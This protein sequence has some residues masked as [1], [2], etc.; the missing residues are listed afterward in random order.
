M[1]KVLA[2]AALVAGFTLWAG[3]GSPDEKANKLFVEACGLVESAKQV[4][5]TSYSGAFEAYKEA[6][7]KI[8]RIISK[9]PSSRL[10]VDLTQGRAMVGPYTL[11]EFKQTTVPIARILAEAEKSL[12][13]CALFPGRMLGH[14]NP[15]RAL[16]MH[17]E[18]ARA[19]ARAGR[20]DKVDAVL[21][22]LLKAM[23]LSEDADDNEDLLEQIASIYKDTGLLE[24]A[25]QVA[26]RISD[27]SDRGRMLAGI[28]KAC[29]DTLQVG[30]MTDIA[31]TIDY[32]FSR[33]EAVIDIAP[34]LLE[35]GRAPR[36]W[37]MLED[38]VMLTRRVGTE[39]G[40][41]TLLARIAR[42]FAGVGETDRA[43]EILAE[44]ERYTQ[45]VSDRSSKSWAI[46]NIALAYMDMDDMT[47]AL[48]WV[49]RISET[50]YRAGALADAVR[51]YA[52]AGDYD[53]VEALIEESRTL[54]HECRRVPAA[55]VEAYVLAGH[56][57][58]AVA[59]AGGIEDHWVQPLLVERAAVACARAGDFDKAL[60]ITALASFE[61]TGS[62]A[63]LAL[64][65]EYATAG[66][67][68][69]A[70][71]LAGEIKSG[72]DLVQLTVKIASSC[73]D[74][75][76]RDKAVELLDGVPVEN[77]QSL[78]LQGYDSIVLLTS[79]AIEYARA[80][81]LE[82]ALEAGNLVPEPYDKLRSMTYVCAYCAD[83]DTSLSEEAQDHL[84][85][86]I[87]AISAYLAMGL[88][89]Y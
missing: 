76:L 25:A 86:M 35:T 30:M 81:R 72:P 33:I 29:T 3:C 41:G 63:R 6:E 61:R 43:G 15:E 20:R 49:S 89:E 11:T 31:R 59:L 42:V 60:E 62:Q 70:V 53:L 39:V 52:E 22:D 34:M 17:L 47:R 8:G 84:H 14:Y 46:Y 37:E 13:A 28:V 9:Y 57:D 27:E 73:N 24:Q 54:G 44:A 66:R 19:Y 4:E 40:K 12:D 48:D 87:G 79:V 5:E 77:W 7:A 58:R 38:A 51:K 64:V 50:R 71:R 10:A 26:N 21:S 67:I 69:E 80:G 45:F 74:L 36:A 75:G 55:A 68:D 18:A 82:Q 83:G 88:P 65:E 78:G 32:E 1:K 2:A 16:G 23:P 56:I 85:Q